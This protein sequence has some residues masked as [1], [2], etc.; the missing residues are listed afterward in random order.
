MKKG[1]LNHITPKPY[2][3]LD[4]FIILE[5]NEF[6]LITFGNR[7]FPAKC[8]S[9]LDLCKKKKKKNIG[10]HPKIKDKLFG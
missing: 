4:H 7:F 1:T 2:K 10:F 6:P 5:F 8:F 3:S 9:L